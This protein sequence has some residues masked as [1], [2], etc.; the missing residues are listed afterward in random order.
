M[1]ETKKVFKGFAGLLL[2]LLVTTALAQ[3]PVAVDQATVGSLRQGGYVIF[4]RHAAT[5][6]R[7]KDTD[8]VNLADCSRQRNLTEYGREQARGIGAAFRRLGIPVG[9]VRSSEFCRCLETGRLAFGRARGDRNLNSFIGQSEL[10]KRRRVLAIR[11]YL[12]S[13]PPAGQNTIVIGHKIMFNQATGYRLREGEAAVFRP[14]GEG[15]YE[16][17]GQ[18]RAEDWAA[19]R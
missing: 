9:E 7:Q 6:H 13:V 11:K 14:L 4:F 1:I 12:A 10:E 19:L 8:R 15:R 5:D 18:I 3:V 16:Y 2:G 17:V